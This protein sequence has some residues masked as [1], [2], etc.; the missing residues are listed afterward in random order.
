MQILNNQKDALITEI[1]HRFG[2]VSGL[3]RAVV[4]DLYC[5]LVVQPDLP[6]FLKWQSLRFNAT[7]CDPASWQ[8]SHDL[9]AQKLAIPDTI[10]SPSKKCKKNSAALLFAI[11]SYFASIVH[12]FLRQLNCATSD[13]TA[14]YTWPSAGKPSKQKAS[15]LSHENEIDATVTQIC[16]SDMLG[17]SNRG[18]DL[19]GA[20]YANLLPG[21]A[22]KRLGE[23]YTPVWLAEHLLDFAG[24][25]AAIASN[26][27]IRLLDPACGSGTFLLAA[28]RR[29]LQANHPPEQIANCIAGFDLNPLAVLMTSANVAAALVSRNAHDNRLFSDELPSLSIACYDSI[30]NTWPFDETG[31]TVLRQGADEKKHAATFEQFDFVVGNPPWLAWDKLPY[32]YR[33][34]TKPLW[35]RYGLFNLSGKDA[36]YGGAKKEFALLMVATSADHFLKTGGKLAMVLPQT[37][38]QT[39]K[40]G[41]GFRCFGGDELPY[42][43]KVLRADDF[44]AMRVFK[45]AATKTATLVF[46][47]GCPT[48]YPVPY[49]S[50][51]SLDHCVRYDAVPVAPQQPGSA[52]QVVPQGASAKHVAG[53]AVLSQASDYTAQLGANTG[54]ANG[55]YWVEIVSHNANGLATVRNLA[56]CSKQTLPVIEAEIETKLLFPLLR[57]R[58]VDRF[59]AL[60]STWSIVVQDPATRKGLPLDVMRSNYPKTLAFLS[61]FET[62]LRNRAAFKKFLADAPF[63]SM[64]NISRETLAPIKVVWRRMDTRVR[65]AVVQAV[66]TSLN[67]SF[68][69]SIKTEFEMTK[70]MSFAKSRPVIPQETCSMIAVDNL[71]EAHYLVSLLNSEAVHQ[72]VATFSVQ[73][74]KG[75][76]S[77]GMLSHLPIR[78]FDATNEAHQKLAQL[79][80]AAHADSTTEHNDVLAEINA[81][82]LE[83]KLLHVAHLGETED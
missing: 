37:I 27:S 18:A 51:Q 57:W 80:L 8:K 66:D 1:C 71:D 7:G 52:W 60:P 47:K 38:L 2:A 16:E 79:A 56:A 25:D 73:G 77:P 32:D 4:S 67:T 33:E 62:Q 10:L 45:D 43:L 76:G 68:G 69:A 35:Q 23:F 14:V 82:V 13:V 75:F 5:E 58:D 30:R 28:I 20:L 34:Q 50:W 63:Y 26:S 3:A 31:P 12:S 64:Y 78:K 48:T 70:E 11:E 6:G 41:N 83:R 39:H 24:F 81:V 42:Q 17:H 36:R 9:I 49:Y 54:G 46:E 15:L 40:T 55:V 53:Q 74:G 22:R 21:A 44:S 61:R 72:R 19:F 29:M 65:A 59:S